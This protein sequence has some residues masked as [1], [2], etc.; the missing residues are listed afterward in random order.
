MD[1]FC[2]KDIIAANCTRICCYEQ[3]LSKVTITAFQETM[4]YFV[5]RRGLLHTQPFCRASNR[6]VRFKQLSFIGTELRE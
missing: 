5:A 3:L 6:Q 2:N 1:S 4:L